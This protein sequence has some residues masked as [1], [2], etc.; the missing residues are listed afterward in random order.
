MDVHAELAQNGVASARHTPVRGNCT[1]RSSKNDPLGTTPQIIKELRQHH[2]NFW[3]NCEKTK[4][5]QCLECLINYTAT[6]AFKKSTALCHYGSFEVNLA[7]PPLK[8]PVLALASGENTKPEV[9]LELMGYPGRNIKEQWD[10]EMSTLKPLVAINGSMQAYTHMYYICIIYYCIYYYFIWL[11][12]VA[13]VFSRFPMFLL[14]LAFSNTWSSF[15]QV[16]AKLL[17]C[18]ASPNGPTSGGIGTTHP[19]SLLS[20]NARSNPYAIDVAN[21]LMKGGSNINQ[22][23]KACVFILHWWSMVKSICKQRHLQAW[24]CCIAIMFG[25]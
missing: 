2:S 1:I 18:R 14:F 9:R 20:I 8:V 21:L 13:H 11:L 10:I 16:I 6:A 12:N 7:A 25:H 5:L 19:V 22:Q 4:F 23:C 3:E 17:E 15:F 24:H